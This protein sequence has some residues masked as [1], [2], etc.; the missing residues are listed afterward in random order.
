M[1]AMLA[2]KHGVGRDKERIEGRRQRDGQG[3]AR[4]WT[5]P[6]RAA[7]PPPASYISGTI[8]RTVQ[9]SSPAP[10]PRWNSPSASSPHRPLLQRI[11][12]ELFGMCLLRGA[13]ST[14]PDDDAGVQPPSRGGLARPAHA[15]PRA[16]HPVVHWSEFKDSSA[17]PP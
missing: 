2:G 5:F 15:M 13:A 4:N 3:Q 8:I 1:E 14:G 10:A 16:V 9:L 11:A 7:A 12:S 6:N 17:T